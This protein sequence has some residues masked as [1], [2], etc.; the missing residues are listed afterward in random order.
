MTDLVPPGCAT[1]V[2]TVFWGGDAAGAAE[3][4]FNPQYTFDSFV[5]GASNRFAHA[6]ARRVADTP[7]STFN[8]L[9][10]YGDFGLGKTHL[11]HA[12]GHHV[13]DAF[14]NRQIR[15][16]STETFMNEFLDS[17]RISASPAFKR[18][19]RAC[20]MLLVDDIEF[21]ENKPGMQEEFFHTFNSLY[22]ADKQIVMTSDRPPRSIATLEHRLRSRLEW[23]LVTHVQPPAL[24]TRV[25]I[26][27][28]KTE[29]THSSVPDDVLELI[30]SRVTD[31]IRDL[32]GALNR[33]FALGSLN[34]A[35]THRRARRNGAPP[36]SGQAATTSDHARDDPRSLGPRVRFR[37]RRAAR[38]EPATTARPRP[39]DQHVRLS[40]GH[41]PQLPGDRTRVRRA[42][43][44]DGHACRRQDF[45]S[46]DRTSASPRSG[47][48]GHSAYQAPRLTPADQLGR[49]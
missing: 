13:R 49:P 2:G 41:R 36:Q 42:R 4:P 18:R 5:V 12:I 31:N 10:I 28:R 22:E 19:Y 24:D 39:T 26:L 11:L 8:P 43:P 37:C 1:C 16:V 21:L 6:A 35:T 34:F 33:V 44:H 7:A 17:A 29:G 40:A 23:G 20:D 27:R 38:T 9:L 15:Y 47:R 14:P 32:E 45:R 46:N 25:S 30:A 3:R 48:R